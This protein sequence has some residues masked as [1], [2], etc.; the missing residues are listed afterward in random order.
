M[1]SSSIMI[2]LGWNVSD[3]QGRKAPKAD[4]GRKKGESKV[5]NDLES[6]EFR[7]FSIGDVEVMNTLRKRFKSLH[8][9]SLVLSTQVSEFTGKELSNNIISI[10]GSRRNSCTAAI[11]QL[12]Q[13]AAR[14]NLEL[15]E[16]DPQADGFVEYYIQNKK[17]ENLQ[18]KTNLRL[19]HNDEKYQNGCDYGLIYRLTS[20]GDT[21]YTWIIMAGITREGTL[22]CLD[23]LFGNLA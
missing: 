18:Y 1:Y 14:T 16:R 3:F 5:T 17:S 10:G 11:L 20:F 4:R 19:R 23:C 7:N 6:S 12:P 8:Q 13:I 15:V 21:P 2:F 9:E 22:A